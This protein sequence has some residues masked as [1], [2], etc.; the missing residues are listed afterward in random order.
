MKPKYLLLYSY[1]DFPDKNEWYKRTD[2]NGWRLVSDRLIH[3]LM[4][5]P[6]TWETSNKKYEFNHDKVRLMLEINFASQGL[7]FIN[8]L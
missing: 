3:H 4:A 5:D 2:N 1:F 8:N 6:V 7:N